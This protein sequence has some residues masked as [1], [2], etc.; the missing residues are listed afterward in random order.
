M[1]SEH[2]ATTVILFH[3]Q[4]RYGF[5]MATTKITITL[6]DDQAKEIR[7]FVAAGR[8]AN[9]S[10]FVQRAVGAAILDAASWREMREETLQQAGGPLSRKERDWADTVLSAKR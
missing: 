7:A 8:A 9:V 1:G 2:Q 10:G 6:R 3:R 5:S 4:P